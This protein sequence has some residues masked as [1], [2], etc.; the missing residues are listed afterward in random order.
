LAAVAREGFADPAGS[1]P[2]SDGDADLGPR[3]RSA[4]R[5]WRFAHDDSTLYDLMFHQRLELQFATGKTP[6]ALLAG[7][8][9][10]RDAVND[11]VSALGMEL[12]EPET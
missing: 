4:V 7:F 12:A 10:L 11:A 6:A 3:E 2:S 5:Y 9:A 1:L 8:D